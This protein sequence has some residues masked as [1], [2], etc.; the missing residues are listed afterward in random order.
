MIEKRHGAT[1]ELNSAL[2]R[3]GT[4]SPMPRDLVK[5]SKREMVS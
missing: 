4:T 2:P 3:A 5:F 1:S